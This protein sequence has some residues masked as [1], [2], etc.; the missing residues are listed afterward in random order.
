MAGSLHTSFLTPPFGRA[1]FFLNGAAPPGGTTGDIDRGVLAF[2]GLQ[3]VE[4]S[5][6]FFFSG[7]AT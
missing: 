4:L 7:R 5:C 3:I 1:L 6:L 2:I